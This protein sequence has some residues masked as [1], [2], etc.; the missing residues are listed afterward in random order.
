MKF[1]MDCE[2]FTN[3]GNCLASEGKKV[4]EYNKCVFQKNGMDKTISKERHICAL[5]SICRKRLISYG[6]GREYFDKEI[7]FQIDKK[8]DIHLRSISKKKKKEKIL[9]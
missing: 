1:K 4:R 2:C 6:K 5:S 7:C 3:G 9:L 8:F